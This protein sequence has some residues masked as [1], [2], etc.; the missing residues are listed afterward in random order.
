MTPDPRQRFEVVAFFPA[1]HAEAV[2]GKVYL[3]GGFWNR[4][5]FPEYPAVIGTMALI[6]VIHVPFHE[7]QE[8]H[9][10]ALG[11]VDADEKASPFHVEGVFRVGAAADLRRGDPTIMPIAVP[12]TGLKIDRAGDYSFTLDVDGSELARFQFRAVQLATP[13]K[14][15]L[16]NPD[17]PE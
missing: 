6:A 16:D 10:F 17:K 8:D 3:N 15:E 13:L 5:N 4:L 2:N 14:F 1:D 11:M 7:Y 12:V 9:K